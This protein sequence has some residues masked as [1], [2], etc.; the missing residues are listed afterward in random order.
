MNKK[1]KPG[2]AACCA[3]GDL[4]I[5]SRLFKALSDPSRVAI[6]VALARGSDPRSVSQVASCCPVDL[7]VVSRHLAKLKEAGVLESRREGKE[8][9]YAVR[10]ED[11][12]GTLRAVADAIEACCPEGIP[13]AKG[14]T[15]DE[16]GRRGPK[17]SRAG[18]RKGRERSR[19]GKPR[20]KPARRRGGA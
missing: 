2:T 4:P 18:V 14:R 7:S 11:L 17:G 15:G 19:A 13:S 16:E 8:V 5:D 3:G 6:L 9:R 20:R 10:F 1:K 12:A